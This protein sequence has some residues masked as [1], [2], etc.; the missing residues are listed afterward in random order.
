MKKIPTCFSEHY[1]AET[2]TAS[3]RK[4]PVVAREVESRGY[5]ELI[6]PGAL[7]VE[8]LRSLHAP[9]YVDAFLEGRG[10]IA[11]SQ[12]WP[13][14]IAIRD[15]VL[16]INAGQLCG[17]RLALQHGLA[18]NIGQGFHH[19][20]YEQGMGYCTFNGL[21]LIAQEFPN[22]RIGVLDCDEHQGNGT[23]QF[24]GRLQNLFNF[25]IY[26]GSFGAPALPRSIN[27]QLNRCADDF[28]AYEYALD[29]GLRQMSEWAVDLII[30]QAGAD[31]HEND[32]LGS[33][34]LTTEQLRLRDRRVFEYAKREGVPIL[35][36]L[37]GGYQIPIE[38]ALA[39][40]HV[41]TFAEAVDVFV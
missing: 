18:A 33:L 39:P 6:D 38:T 2:T 35:F 41:T 28:G 32:P 27:R 14:S 37:A 15:G 26:G 1:F 30:F 36:V 5:A 21:A 10:A 20:V 16:A 19:A 25:T 24:T 13:W 8:K 29:E 9:A 4:L 17:A 12:G 22:L 40:L 31:P 34:G 23:A 7:D 3:M 11:S